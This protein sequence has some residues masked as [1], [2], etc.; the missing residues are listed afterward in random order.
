M[1]GNEGYRRLVLAATLLALVV[2]VLGAYTR[3]SDAGLGCPDWPGCYGRLG[4]PV[5]EEARAAAN[6]AFPERAVEPRKAWTEMIHRY[7]AGTLGLLVLALAVL[8]W[9]RRSDPGQPVALPALLLGVVVFQALLGMWTVT[10]LLKPLVVMGH[11]LGGFTTLALLWWLALQ[12]GALRT[13]GPALMAAGSTRPLRSWALLGLAVIY[14]QI[15]LGGWVSANYA[16]L[17]CPDFPRCQGAW[18][19]ATDFADAF[20]L[21]RGTGVNYEFGVLD[22]TARVT[23]HLAHRIGAVVTLLYLGWLGLR[24]LGA[25]RDPHVVLSGIA[26]LALIAVQV[27]LGISNVVLGLPLGVAVA[28]NAVGALLLLAVVTLNHMLRPPSP[29]RVQYEAE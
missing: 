29:V 26:L 28:H 17:A 25:R 10:L 13:G 8:A 20:T 6:A 11:L 5:S 15:A 21:W 18:W 9:I 3:L 1:S 16:A 22:N 27:S 7:A 14:L 4:A 19:P 12:L 23:V 2:V 24:A